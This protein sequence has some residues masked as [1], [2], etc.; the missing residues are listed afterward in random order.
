MYKPS[1]IRDLIGVKG[2]GLQQETGDLGSQNPA[3]ITFNI[4][5]PSKNERVRNNKN[6]PQKMCPGRI[7]QSIEAIEEEGLNDLNLSLD[8]KFISSGCE[9]GMDET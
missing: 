7:Q 6:R 9:I 2:F 4:A 5:I 1:C 3:D 8:E